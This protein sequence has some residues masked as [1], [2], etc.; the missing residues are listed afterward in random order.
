MTPL[1]Q[2][3]GGRE[4]SLSAWILL[5]SPLSFTSRG[6]HDILNPPLPSK[7]RL[8]PVNRHLPASQCPCSKRMH[9]ILNP[10]L[11]LMRALLPVNHG[12]A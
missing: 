1:L 3:G 2:L 12:L 6:L 5:T 10:P 8:L 9:D 7:R 11:P 4:V